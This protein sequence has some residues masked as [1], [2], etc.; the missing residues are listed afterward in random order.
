MSEKNK[1][2]WL[3][4]QLPLLEENNII[5]EAGGLKIKDYYTGKL[6]GLNYS[7]VTYFL[8]GILGALL[9]VGGIILLFIFNWSSLPRTVKTGA[10]FLITII[11][12]GLCIWFLLNE[13]NKMDK[14]TQLRLRESF[15]IVLSILF[16][17][18]IALIG[19]IYHLPSNME[20]F[21][22]IWAVSTLVIIYLFDSLL[23]VV[24]YLVLIISLASVMQNKE[25]VG[26]A[27]YPLFFLLGP[28]YYF[29]FKKYG[30]KD[31]L[32]LTFLH[33]ASIAALICGL[34]ITLEKV[35]PGLWICAYANLFVIFYLISLFVEDESKSFFY[36][37]FRV[38]AFLGVGL[39]AYL[40]SYHWPWKDIGWSYIR[41][42]E[43]FHEAAAIFDYAV[44]IIFPI[45]TL[46]MGFLAVKREKNIN[47][48]FAIFGFLTMGLYLLMAIAHLDQYIPAW[49]VNGY[50]FI[51]G[52]YLLYLG[53]IK[54]SLLIVNSS[55]GLVFA[56]V[57]TRFF[58]Q[59]MS[60]LTRGIAFI[61]VGIIILVVNSV[62]VRKFKQKKQDQ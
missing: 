22:L 47:Y 43:R 41:D 7:W 24:L 37:P 46:I 2:K 57:I 27:F 17:A 56:T 14:E 18:S 36:R 30:Q 45:I 15:S 4:K 59:D 28:F 10:A 16:G 51:L 13:N 44:V 1:I 23:A 9:V 61:A 6:E 49:A 40:L 34:G 29:E 21:L 33:Y 8:L 12:Q 25:S 62:L 31:N 42:G 38:A 39:F 54:E 50:I 58:D 3:L 55:M 20:L 11:P 32:R 19:Q 52:G 60:T 5:D 53:D 35:I 48:P 26:L